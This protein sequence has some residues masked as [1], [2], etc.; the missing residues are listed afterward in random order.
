[1]TVAS[2]S[3][4][5]TVENFLQA[6][7]GCRPLPDHEADLAAFSHWAHK[8]HIMGQVAAVHLDVD[9]EG[10][11]CQLFANAR[12]R[13]AYDQRMLAYEANRIARALEGSH[14]R[15]I[16]LKGSAYVAQHL[17]AGVGRRVSD[18]DILVTE[19]ELPDVERHL[20]DAGWQPEE[21]TA[22][23][24]DQRYYRQ[25]MHE[26]PPY[27]H[28]RRRTLIDVHHRLLPRTSRIAPDHKAMASEAQDIEGSP[29]RVFAP[30]DRFIHSAIHIFGDGALETPARSLIELYYLFKD[31]TEEERTGLWSRATSVGAQLPV[32]AALWGVARYFDVEEAQGIMEG[33]K[34]AFLLRRSLRGVLT[35]DAS[36]GLAA[37]TLL[38]LRSHY[39][40]MPLP[41]LMR[42]LTAKALR[43]A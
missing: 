42:H 12:L 34:P 38:Y 27:R 11:L 10:K 21:T 13:T 35:A 14:V 9:P 41:L 6:A 8:E 30:I 25:W 28:Q 32:T 36:R 20:V 33:P 3:P 5:A 23:P 19:D 1:M 7:V 18:I 39:L 31:L 2:L 37:K 15:P 26:L 16:L 24:Y 29:L 17:L 43:R 22:N 40:R 4:E